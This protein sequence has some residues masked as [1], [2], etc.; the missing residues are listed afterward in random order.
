MQ[1]EQLITL[2]TAVL[3]LLAHELFAGCL[4]VSSSA[5]RVQSYQS[6]IELGQVWVA[7][8]FKRYQW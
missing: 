7:V 4:L 3:F 5:A 8:L 1:F 2:C 6:S